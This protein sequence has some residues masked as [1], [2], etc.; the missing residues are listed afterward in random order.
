MRHGQSTYNLENRFTGWLDVPL[1]NEGIE[2]AKEAAIKLKEY[3][4]DVAY[5]STL[6]RAVDTLKII[7]DW[8]Q[9]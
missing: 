8:S 3:K 6:K 2:E 9:F 1:S 5:T 4:I 7:L